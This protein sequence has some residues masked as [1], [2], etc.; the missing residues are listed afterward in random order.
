[1]DNQNWSGSKDK[2]ES[3]G[4]KGSR[5]KRGERL[6]LMEVF[7]GF[8]RVFLIFGIFWF[9]RK[10]FGIFFRYSLKNSLN[11]GEKL[12]VNYPYNFQ[13]KKNKNSMKTW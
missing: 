3:M 4:M 9:L 1:M 11:Q 7:L 6:S 5:G 13:F 10:F 2:G 12:F 8:W